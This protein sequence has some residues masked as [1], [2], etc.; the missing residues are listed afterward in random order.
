MNRLTRRHPTHPSLIIQYPRH[1]RNFKSYLK[2]SKGEI[3]TYPRGK[4][5][6]YKGKF[7]YIA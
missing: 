4:M 5:Y 1:I 3:R 2:Q 6:I 7:I